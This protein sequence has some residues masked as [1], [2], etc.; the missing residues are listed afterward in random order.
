MKKILITEDVTPII[1]REK[2]FL[3]REGVKL[4]MAATNDDVMSVHRAEKANVI[5]TTLKAPGMKSEALCSAI[6]A[7]D[8]LRTVSIIIICPDNA[9]DIERSA[10]CKANVVLAMPVDPALL[11]EKVR[12]LLEVSWRESYRVLVSVI[13][14]GSNR[15]VPFFGRSGNIS[16]TGMLI[17]SEKVLEK[18][19]QLTC[20]FFLPGSAR[21]KT[22]GEIVRVLKQ[23]GGSKTRQYGVRFSPLAS[24]ARSAIEEFVDRRSQVSTSRK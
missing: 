13:V 16:S 18:G 3:D 24:E 10:Q 12:Q 6:R 11:L 19:D 8:A 14:E 21:I 1:S 9:A 5:I 23:A 4:L 7:D 20:S 17:E 2:S 22:I 15:D